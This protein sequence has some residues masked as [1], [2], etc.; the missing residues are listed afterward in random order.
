MPFLKS[1]PENAGPPLIYT[2]YPEIYGPW[3][4]MS[5]QLMNGPS[6]FSYPEREMLFALAAGAAGSENVYIAHNA[7]AV[8]L[9][10]PEGLLARLLAGQGFDDLA[11]KLRPAVHYAILLGR[12]PNSASQADV[13]AILAAGWD[14]RAVHDLIA[15]CARAAFMHRLTSGFG[16]A[17]LTPEQ[18][19]E[20]ARQRIAKGYVNL[21][22][23]LAARNATP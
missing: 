10:L 14:D 23:E 8:A 4:D 6:H 13:D 12:A 3:S 15:I 7:V 20:R 9:G 22:P 2:S 18:A 19:K 17:P 11:P 21:Y 16:F 1:L 5:E